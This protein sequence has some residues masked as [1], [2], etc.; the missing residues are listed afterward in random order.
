VLLKGE[1][2]NTLEEDL[3]FFFLGFSAEVEEVISSLVYLSFNP[4]K[5]LLLTD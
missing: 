4:L 3:E 1:T 2:E 5:F